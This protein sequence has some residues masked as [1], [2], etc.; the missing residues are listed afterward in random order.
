MQNQK[1]RGQNIS[2]NKKL[3]AF[4]LYLKL[5]WNVADIQRIKFANVVCYR[6]YTNLEYKFSSTFWE[7][8]KLL[9][10]Y[11]NEALILQ[12]LIHVPNG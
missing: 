5:L 3:S 9:G 1:Q 10:I 2:Q 4:S 11:T 8:V 6:N 12:T 7:K